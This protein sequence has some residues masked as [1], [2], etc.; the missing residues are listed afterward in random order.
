[1]LEILILAAG[2]IKHKLNFIK[3]AFNLP[4]LL[5]INTRNASSLIIIDF[6]FKHNIKV[7]LVINKQDFD[8]VQNE[9]LY[10]LNQIN[11]ITV[12]NSHSIIETLFITLNKVNSDDLIINLV[13]TIPTKLVDKN[14]YLVSN[15]IYKSKEYSLN[16]D[17]DY[18][19]IPYEL[20]AV[21]SY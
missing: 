17:S 9:L 18:K 15:E 19:R 3:F 21:S 16:L 13:S 7:N 12:K 14:I 1:M 6:Y 11:L 5:T 8:E 2:S 4:A 10:Y 20:I